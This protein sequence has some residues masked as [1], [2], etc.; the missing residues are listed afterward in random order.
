M[1]HSANHYAT[2]R[3]EA[4]IDPQANC[5]I[6][7]SFLQQA[8]A[9]LAQEEAT[10]CISTLAEIFGSFL[11]RRKRR[12][13]TKALLV[14]GPTRTG[15][16]QVAYVARGLVGGSPSGIRAVSLAEHF[17]VEPLIGASA[18]IADDAVK[19][20]EFLDAEWFKVI[21]DGSP[22]SVPRKNQQ[23]WNGCLDIPVLLTANHLPRVKDQSGAV[24]NRALIMRMTVQRPEDDPSNRK[25]AEE[26]IEGE[27][28]GV[29]NWA[30][31]G[32][33][34]LVARG[35][36]SPPPVMVKAMKTY[37][38]SNSPV[39]TWIEA[40][41]EPDPAYMVD[42]RDLI[43]SFNGWFALEAGSEAKPLGARAL[44]PAMRSVLP[45]VDDHKIREARYLT[46]VRLSDEGLATWQL[47]IDSRQGAGFS[48]NNR[49]DVNRP[50][51]AKKQVVGTIPLAEAPAKSKTM[52]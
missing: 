1:P 43:A 14:I 8:F 35:H 2:F 40:A 11:I 18:W 23:D 48:P 5:P 9:D 6:W 19:E 39:A 21:V 37:V 12:E 13:L 26:I 46:G 16:S 7:L 47:F 4:N 3:I 49:L 36:F 38:S 28:G 45:H 42:R 27:L 33:K 25:I 29:L 32:W 41:I 24:Y 44:F 17:G 31:A 50:A 15:K 20:S 51:P 10:S 34:R 30:I 22:I 52:F